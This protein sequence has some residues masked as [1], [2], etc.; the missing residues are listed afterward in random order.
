MNKR[1]YLQ[2]APSG[3][4]QPERLVTDVE[5]AAR[6]SISRRHVHVL[7]SRGQLR[8][9]RLG[10]SVRFPLNENLARVLGDFAVA[11]TGRPGF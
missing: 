1:T 4:D 5:L 10:N 11:C 8:A 7:R 9:V 2:A 3:M 6:L